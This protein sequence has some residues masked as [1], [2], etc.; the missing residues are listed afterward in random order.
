[1]L[2]LSAVLTHALVIVSVVHLGV[3]VIDEVLASL[4]RLWVVLLPSV[5]LLRGLVRIP[6]V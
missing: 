3:V 4:V 5:A 6:D 2:P 1:M